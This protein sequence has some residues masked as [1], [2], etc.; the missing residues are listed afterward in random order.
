M[1]VDTVLLSY[2]G[3]N[4]LYMAGGIMLLVG[5]LL[6]SQTINSTPTLDSAPAIVLLE[7]VPEKVALVNAIFV[8][9]TFVLVLPTMILR[10]SRIWLK[11][12][13]WMVIV[14]GLFTLVIGLIIWIET[15]RTRA[16]LNTSW[17]KQTPE[18]QSLLQQRFDCCGYYNSTSPPFVTDATCSTPLIAAEKQGCVGPFSSFVNS[19]LDAIFTGIFGIV[20]F[21]MILLISVA[22]VSKD[23][24]EKE[25][26]RLID[27]KIGVGAI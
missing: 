27:A 21:D 24:K 7:M 26:Y 6:F 20:A 15:L 1:K 11:L 17:G 4:F 5:S 13:G 12:Q 16:T 18:V 19:T 23:R 2:A 9:A 22:V 10:T 8:F 3:A 25:R 14:S